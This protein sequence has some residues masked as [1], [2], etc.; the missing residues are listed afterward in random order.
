MVDDLKLLGWIL[1]KLGVILF[2]LSRQLPQV[3]FVYAAF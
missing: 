2:I 3:E 1:L